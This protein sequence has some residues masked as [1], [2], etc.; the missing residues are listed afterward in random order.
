[1]NGELEELGKKARR[2]YARKWRAANPEKARKIT[3]NYWIRRAQ[4]E[5][6]QEADNGKD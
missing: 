5:L 2:E 4:R 6:Q 1:M 3:E